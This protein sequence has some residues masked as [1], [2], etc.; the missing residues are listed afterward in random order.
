MTKVKLTFKNDKHRHRWHRFVSAH[1]Y[2][3][4]VGIDKCLWVSRHL[5]TIPNMLNKYTLKNR[6]EK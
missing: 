1:V 4:F 5:M 6:N 2:F 3:F